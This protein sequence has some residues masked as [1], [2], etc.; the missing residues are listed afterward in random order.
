MN[1]WHQSFETGGGHSQAQPCCSPHAEHC[2]LKPCWCL[3]GGWWWGQKNVDHL[4]PFLCTVT[5]ILHGASSPSRALRAGVITQ[6]FTLLRKGSP[7]QHPCRGLLASVSTPGPQ[8]ARRVHHA[9]SQNTRVPALAVALVNPG[10][11]GHSD[12]YLFSRTV[13][14]TIMR[15]R[16]RL[17]QLCLKAVCGTNNAGLSYHCGELT[18]SRCNSLCFPLSP[19]WSTGPHCWE[20]DLASALKTFCTR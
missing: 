12:V 14:P 1:K 11:V 6:P 15:T 3:P 10:Q 13:S 8:E 9:E 19:R 5:S 16:H 2:P 4:Q 7:P 17:P 18:A 20:K